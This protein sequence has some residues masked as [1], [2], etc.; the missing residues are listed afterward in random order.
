MISRARAK[1]FT[2]MGS[3]RFV[4]IKETGIDSEN[5]KRVFVKAET[6]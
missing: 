3:V 4:V 5:G 2:E 6:K 1:E